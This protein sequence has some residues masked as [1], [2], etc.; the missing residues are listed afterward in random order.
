MSLNHIFSIKISKK[1]PWQRFFN[2]KKTNSHQLF[3]VAFLCSLYF[4]ELHKL[5]P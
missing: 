4:I 5:A 2:N 1:P 3:V